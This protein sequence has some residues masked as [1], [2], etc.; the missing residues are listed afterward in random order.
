MTSHAICII[1]AS[2]AVPCCITRSSA[3]KLTRT[4]VLQQQ[5]LMFTPSVQCVGLCC[6]SW[7]MIVL[8]VAAALV[9]FLDHDARRMIYWLAAAVLTA[10]VTF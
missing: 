2:E 6:E 10:A 1:Y 7:I 5:L 9:Y 3:P 8:D 4:V